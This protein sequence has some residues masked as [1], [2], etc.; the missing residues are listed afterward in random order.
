MIYDNIPQPIPFY[1]SQQRSMFGKVNC[2]GQRAD[3]IFFPNDRTVP[4]GTV[5]SL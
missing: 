3:G 4:F 2:V 5:F 1:G